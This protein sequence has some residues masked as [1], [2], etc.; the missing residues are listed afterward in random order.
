MSKTAKERIAFVNEELFSF[1]FTI[2]EII[3]F[4]ETIKKEVKDGKSK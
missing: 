1:G 2:D 4:L 3:N